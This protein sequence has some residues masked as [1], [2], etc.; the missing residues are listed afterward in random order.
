MAA[1]LVMDGCPPPLHTPHILRSSLFI[2]RTRVHTAGG[3]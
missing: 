3:L 2:L 1:L